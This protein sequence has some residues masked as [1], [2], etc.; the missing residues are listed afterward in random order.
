G[1]VFITSRD[2]ESIKKATAMVDAV[3]KEYK[4]GDTAR[5]K[6]VKTFEFGAM[7][8]LS[9]NQSGLIHVSKLAPYRVNRVTDIVNVGDA[10]EVKVTDIDDQG[11]L[12]LALVSGGRTQKPNE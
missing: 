9:K 1:S 8:E 7:V 11:R 4:A 6:V 5:G 2:D 10:V 3:T 12:N